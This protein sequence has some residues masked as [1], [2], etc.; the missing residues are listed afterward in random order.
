MDIPQTRTAFEP[1]E[2]S[3]KVGDTVRWRNRGIVEHSVTCDPAK[4]RD[5]AHAAFPKGAQPFDSG[6]LG[7]DGVFEHTFTV[8]GTYLYF[9]AEHE[10]M[11]TSWAGLEEVRLA[12]GRMSPVILAH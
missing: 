1:A 2:L 11:G 6:I 3:V 7:E 12:R 5:P 9:C 10:T 8:A 4:A